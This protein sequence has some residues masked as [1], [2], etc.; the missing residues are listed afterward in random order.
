MVVHH[1]WFRSTKFYKSL[2]TIRGIEI[3]MANQSRMQHILQTLMS[4][5]LYRILQEF[6]EQSKGD[7]I[8]VV[9]VVAGWTKNEPRNYSVRL[10]TQQRLQGYYA[11]HALQVFVFSIIPP[12][13]SG[14]MPCTSLPSPFC[15]H[16]SGETYPSHLCLL[17]SKQY[18]LQ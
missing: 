4:P 3:W 13:L 14:G 10:V 12:F 2:S 7:N 1:H 17:P 6:A 16:F 5:W 8:E 15:L 11:P 18:F 9:Y